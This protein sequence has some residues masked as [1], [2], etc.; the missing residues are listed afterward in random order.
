SELQGSR[1]GLA[2]SLYGRARAAVAMRNFI[3]AEGY[4]T[5]ARD[6]LK[7]R[8]DNK[9]MYL[10]GLL[11]FKLAIVKQHIG[12]LNESENLFRNALDQ[13]NRTE[14]FRNYGLALVGC[15]EL[16]QST[17]RYAEALTRLEE[18]IALFRQNGLVRDLAPALIVSGQVLS[19]LK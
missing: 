4:L 1:F 2:W 12:D 9:G 11:N 17:G 15:G 7:L 13:L 8:V 3:E 5:T 10:Q 16:Y 19:S 14:H 6:C 18:A